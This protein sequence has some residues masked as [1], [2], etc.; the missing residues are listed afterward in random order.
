MRKL[1]LEIPTIHCVSCVKYIQSHLNEFNW[2]NEVSIDVEKKAWYIIYDDNNVS[3]DYIL[4]V[5]NENA[6]HKT[7]VLSDSSFLDVKVAADSSENLSEQANNIDSNKTEL[8][9][10]DVSGMHCASCALLITKVLWSTSWVKEAI[11]NFASEKATVKFDPTSLDAEKIKATIKNAWYDAVVHNDS[12]NNDSEKRSL[13]TRKWFSRFLWSAILSVPMIIFMIYDF[14][15]WLKYETILMPYS[16]LISFFLATPV[17]FV[18]WREY[19]LWAYAALRMRTFNMF[20]LISVWTLVAYVYSLYSYFIYYSEYRTILWSNGMKVPNIYFEVAAFLIMF[21]SLWKYLEAKAK[22]KTSEAVSALVSLAPKKAIIK[23]SWINTEVFIEDIV[24]GDIV[25]VRPW[26]KVA[27]DWV[28]ISWTSSIDES[29]LTGE[30][31]PVDKT[32]WS[33]VYA[34]TLNK[35]WSFEFEVKQTWKDTTLSRIIKLIEEAQWSKAPIEWFTDKVSEIFVPVVL[36]IAL[37]VFIVWYLYLWA[38]LESSLLY[39]S[40]VIVIACP[41]ALWLAT[42]TAIMVWTWVWASNWILI[43]GWEPLEIVCKVNVI[44]FDKTGTITKWTPEVTDLIILDEKNQKYVRDFIFSTEEKSEHPLAEAIV[45]K[46]KAEWAS[47]ITV[48]YF[49]SIPWWWVKSKFNSSF[50]TIWNRRLVKVAPDNKDI[51]EKVERMELEGKTVMFA[52]IDNSLVAII[53]VSDVVKPTSFDAIKWLKEMWMKVYMLTGDNIR[54]A[55]YIANKVW[56]EDII[57][58]VLP[59]DK[60]SKI[61]WIQSTW[62]V[63]AMVWDWINDSPALAQ[64]DLW[65]VMW[66]GADVAL[67]SWQIIVMHNDINDIIT[68]IK[69]SKETVW[70]IKQNLFFSLFYNFLGIPIAAWLFIS[71]WLS[72]KP[73]FAWLAMALSSVS[74]VVNSLSLKWFNPKKVN[75]LS[76]LAPFLMAIFFIFIFWEFSSLSINNTITYA[77]YNKWVTSAIWDLLSSNV[78]KIWYDK[79]NI[80]KIMVKTDKIGDLIL[81]SAWIGDLKY[82]NVILWSEE[83]KMMQREWLIKWVWSEIKGFFGV[84]KVVITWILSPTWTMLDHVHIMDKTTFDKL[85]LKE[86]LQMVKTQNGKVESYFLYDEYNIPY[87][88]KSVLVLG[89]RSNYSYNWKNYLLSYTLF[90]QEPEMDMSW[91]TKTDPNL[92]NISSMY[93]EKHEWLYWNNLLISVLPLKTWTMLDKF[94]YVPR[95]FEDNYLKSKSK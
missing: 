4:K 66:S 5:I 77:T 51:L 58:E 56:I 64:A 80:P 25:V 70:K 94:Y 24:V 17:L 35:L 61:K 72:L 13:D 75:L 41:C 82:G 10:F 52:S 86:D 55:T 67:E 18:I 85:E 91:Q 71:Y 63:V 69:L 90:K 57:A 60:S 43:K 83:A 68:A 3:S 38:W 21:V 93:Y 59:E 92:T 31:M 6:W 29:M 42:P 36:V 23:R 74:V 19:F 27:L 1:T 8:A 47:S 95:A 73:E 39:F 37:I 9:I 11:V 84:D 40:A 76:K 79:L 46:L 28:V 65:I 20:S 88:L 7:E 33:K 26:E 48:D 87:K 49:E 22:W 53:W 44:V 50:L 15:P 14:L 81:F 54:T 16:A 78:S 45:K 34:W 2:I 30:S 12:E 89:D 32:I 62:K